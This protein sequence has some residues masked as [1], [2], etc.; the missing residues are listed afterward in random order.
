MAFRKYS[1]LYIV[2]ATSL[3]P[4]LTI[5]WKTGENRV[6]DNASKLSNNLLI[7]LLYT[8]NEKLIS[9]TTGATNDHPYPHLKMLIRALKRLFIA[10]PSNKNI[11]FQIRL[12]PV[13][14]HW[15]SQRLFSTCLT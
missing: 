15:I 10:R 12:L 9:L 6:R 1:N 2:I 4:V 11:V 8:C 3:K 14:A 13:N 7:M 5:Y